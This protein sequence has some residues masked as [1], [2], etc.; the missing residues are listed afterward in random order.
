[1]SSVGR[2]GQQAVS[3]ANRVGDNRWVDRTA[4]VGLAARGLV[5]VLIGVLAIQIAFVDR[6]KEADQKGAFQTLAQNAWG[7]AVL[8]IVVVGFL[9]YAVWLATD[10]VSG[11]WQEREK[12]KRTAR[13]VES[14]VKAVAYV[15][16][17]VLAFRVVTGSSSG[18]GGETVTA[19]VLGMTGG[20]FLVG[21]AG[22]VIIAVAALL[23]WRG[24]RTKFEDHLSLG[25]LSPAARSAV[26][27]LGKVGYIA[28]GIV[29]ALVGIL[30][31]AAAVTF[32][33]HKARG[34][35]P[36]LRT[37]AAQP[38]GPWLLG[39]VALGLICFGA[40]SFVEARYRRL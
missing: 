33:P 13:R 23:A 17:A 4:R 38:Y 37:L 12:S 11:H 7:K 3:A 20:R 10:A 34:F 9:G 36:A 6:A 14:G 39:A 40:Y 29:F 18:Q 26:I 32:D 22:V 21:L 8:W 30:V 28:R 5:Y 15:V 25:L 19:K 16:L 27:N 35:D 31:V 2:T 24:V 1:M